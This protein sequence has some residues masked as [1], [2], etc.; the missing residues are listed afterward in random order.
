MTEPR[1]PLS[2]DAEFHLAVAAAHGGDHWA[3]MAIGLD[4][5]LV[6]VLKKLDETHSSLRAALERASTA[7]R[8][9]NEYKTDVSLESAF[10]ELDQI[11]RE[12]RVPGFVLSDWRGR[13]LNR[14]LKFHHAQEIALRTECDSARAWAR[15]WK[16]AAKRWRHVP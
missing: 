15:R 8:E 14:H 10:E 3:R 4:A 5:T 16:A 12:Y 6:A 11:A 1:G 9:R 7:E 13:W 2:G